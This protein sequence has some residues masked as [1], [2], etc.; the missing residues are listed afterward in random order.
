MSS[1]EKLKEIEQIVDVNAIKYKN[2][3]IWPVLRYYI[4]AKHT[5]NSN[6][7]KPDK[8]IFKSVLKNLF[9]GFKNYFKK[10]EY[11]FI[12]SSD[13]RV[14]IDDLFIDKS[15]TLIA[16][17][18]SK[19]WIIEL[20]SKGHFKKKNLP[21]TPI[22]S[23]YPL[24]VLTWIYSK[25]LGSSK[26]AGQEE[27]EYVLNELNINVD[28]KN[29]CKNHYAQYKMMLFLA[30]WKKFKSVFVVCHYTNMGYIRAFRR[31]NIPVIEIQHGLIAKG[32]C[33]YNLYTPMDLSCYPNFLLTFGKKEQFVFSKDNFFI[34]ANRVVPVGHFYIDYIASKYS[35]D[36]KLIDTQNK[37]R[38]TIAIVSQNHPVERKLIE[39]VKE[40][41]ELD[42]TILYVFVP[43]TYNKVA[44]D[45]GFKDNIILTPWLNVY[46]IIWHADFHSTVFST[47][48]LEAP[49]IGVRNILI[50]IENR[51]KA[52]FED[53]LNDE[54]ITKYSET[55]KEYID[56]INSASN[57]S[58]EI[59]I[60]KNASIII[61]DY[62]QN[63]TNF[64]NY[65]EKS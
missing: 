55:P 2:L 33:A 9:Y 6:P 46:E 27:L 8:S 40:V 57:L 60:N 63:I 65:L 34:T 54:E 14:I 64:I 37:Y 39:F 30:R 36:Q 42:K 17:K 61:P 43:R 21:S 12:S 20:P 62:R 24:Y 26:I 53:K 16:Q 50:N 11:L 44:K 56:I 41:A 15:V 13:Q 29:I 48:A 19:S 49:S 51:S 32:H 10:H 52:L 47:C 7:K 3:A 45:Y 58:R 31:L 23:K 4:C 59:I 35:G 25:L 18:L 5:A 38:K 22:S 1:A 28:Y